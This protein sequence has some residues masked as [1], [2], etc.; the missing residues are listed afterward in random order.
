VP[1]RPRTGERSINEVFTMAQPAPQ[2]IENRS[3]ATND[4]QGA[5]AKRHFIQ[6]PGMIAG[7]RTGSP[8]R[9]NES[10]VF[11]HL[12]DTYERESLKRKDATDISK[13]RV[14]TNNLSTQKLN[15]QG[16]GEQILNEYS[17]TYDYQQYQMANPYERGTDQY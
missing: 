7:V 3:L 17:S 4:I 9:K 14:V 15:P 5:S 8:K 6:D 12:T 1:Y 10:S 2:R 13:P 16:Y 11:S